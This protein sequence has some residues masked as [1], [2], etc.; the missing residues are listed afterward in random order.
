MSLNRLTPPRWAGFFSGMC[1]TTGAI[2]AALC[3]VVLD[4][5]VEAC[6]FVQRAQVEPVARLYRCRVIGKTFEHD[7]WPDDLI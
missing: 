2:A 6:Q 5:V 3:H 7:K 4:H 1:D